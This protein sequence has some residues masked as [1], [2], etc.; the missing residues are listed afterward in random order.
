M[1]INT[2][3]AA[4]LVRA[5]QNGTAFTRT[6]TIG[7]QVLGLPSE[8]IAALSRKLHIPQRDWATFAEDGYAEAFLRDFL[9]AETITS[10]D[11]SDYEAVDVVQ[12]FN[13]PLDE[14]YYREFDVVIDGGTME[15]IFDVK[16]VLANYM[17]MVKIG[18]SVFISVPANN[19]CG[20]GFYQFSPE[21]FYRVFDT[22]NGFTAENV[23]FI[24]TPF[25][26]VEASPHQ[27]LYDVVDPAA[28]RHR[29]QIVT[30]KPLTVFV[31]ARRIND[32]PPFRRP[33]LQ[34]DFVTEWETRDAQTINPESVKK[35]SDEK[36]QTPKRLAYLSLRQAFRLKRKQRRKN[37]LRNKRW[38]QRITI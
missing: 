33:P 37:S 16:T 35:S 17:N 24:E 9:G 34:S 31:H 27:I 32:D 30:D 22:D 29:V 11:Y 3:F 14:K 6:A 1:G 5:R 2:A 18:G 21:L 36:Q 19:L 12:D 38:F 7:R 13:A 20:H 25:L 15:H 10:F 4:L 8:E 26:A 23:T 28:I